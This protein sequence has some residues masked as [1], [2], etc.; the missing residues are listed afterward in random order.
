ME[1]ATT[2]GWPLLAQARYVQL[3]VQF[4]QTLIETK[5]HTLRGRFVQE[6]TKPHSA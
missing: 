6:L 2:I 4:T 5:N 3:I 1:A